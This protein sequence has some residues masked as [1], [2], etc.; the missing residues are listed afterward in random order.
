MYNNYMDQFPKIVLMVLFNKPI[1]IK[2]WDKNDH[3]FVICFESEF[4]F[5]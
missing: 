2:L 4:I 5:T 3:G 1:D